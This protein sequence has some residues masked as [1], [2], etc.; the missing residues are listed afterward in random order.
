MEFSPGYGK[1]V[2]NVTLKSDAKYIDSEVLAWL[3][4]IL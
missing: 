4:R 3:N 2:M 1:M